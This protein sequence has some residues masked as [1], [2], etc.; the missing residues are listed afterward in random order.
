MWTLNCRS[1]TRGKRNSYIPITWTLARH[2]DQ[3][4]QS[5]GY[6]VDE[7][8]VR[9]RC[10][11][12]HHITDREAAP[13]IVRSRYDRI[14]Q[15]N[16][17]RKQDTKSFSRPDSESNFLLFL[18]EITP[19]LHQRKTIDVGLRGSE[20]HCHHTRA[21]EGRKRRWVCCR[22]KSDSEPGMVYVH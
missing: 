1:L 19:I 12:V 8:R 9:D 2:A 7:D 22:L 3:R 20:G 11:L 16:R 5:A 14:K 17:Q 13:Y 21:G 18:M 15:C 10:R 4:G 6:Q